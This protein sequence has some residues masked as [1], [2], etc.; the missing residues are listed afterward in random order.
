[1]SDLEHAAADEPNPRGR[2]WPDLRA[3]M[4]LAG[5]KPSRSVAIL[6]SSY[7]PWKGYFDL[8]HRVDEFVLFDT[9]QYRRNDW[10]N[11]N[12]IKTAAGAAWLSIPVKAA[13]RQRI[14]DT[15]IDDPSWNERHWKTL[16]HEYSRAR[17]FRAYRDQF[18]ELYRGCQET[19]LSRWNYRFLTNICCMLGITT[20]FSWSSDYPEVEGKTERLVQWC[21]LLDAT[22]Y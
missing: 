18:E 22:E 16:T 17:F 4:L 19:L 10:R 14:L 2:T 3:S 15:Q 11:R 13:Y 9:A 1:M 21:K 6:Q 7:I 5:T 20:R 12:K 8:I